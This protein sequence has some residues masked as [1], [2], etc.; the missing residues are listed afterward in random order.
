MIEK[1]FQSALSTTLFKLL[2]RK[3][4]NFLVTLK[5]EFKVYNITQPIIE[6]LL[7]KQSCE[8]KDE[9]PNV[10]VLEYI[11]ET[12]VILKHQALKLKST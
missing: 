8:F 5:T 7:A 10:Q 6:V 11:Y 2:L 1:V 9:T 3:A 12:V 4:S